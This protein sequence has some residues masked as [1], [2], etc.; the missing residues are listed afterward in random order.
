MRVCVSEIQSRK[1]WAVFADWSTE[2]GVV[3]LSR[4]APDGSIQEVRLHTKSA[5]ETRLVFA[6]LNQ[7]V[8]AQTIQRNQLVTLREM[9][10]DC[11]TFVEGMD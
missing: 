7:L 1:S 8:D 2:H 4:T 10:L 6:W 5:E 3:V 11:L 9:V